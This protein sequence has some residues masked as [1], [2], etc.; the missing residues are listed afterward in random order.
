MKIK[1]NIFPIC[2]FLIYISIVILLVLKLLGI[3]NPG[4]NI[5]VLSFTYGILFY[6]ITLSAIKIIKEEWR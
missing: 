1:D 5:D 3:W 4:Y 2:V 6:G